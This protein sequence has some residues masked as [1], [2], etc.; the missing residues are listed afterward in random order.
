M[1][2]AGG[3]GTT[4]EID[5]QLDGET[6]A[7]SYSRNS[8]R[9]SSRSSTSR[10]CKLQNTGITDAGLEPL[11]G[12]SNISSI[13]LEGTAISDRGFGSLKTISSLKY[14]LLGG[15][16]RYRGGTLAWSGLGRPLRDY[17]P[18]PYGG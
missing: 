3:E 9:T 18:E 17:P 13:N 5:I 2:R 1:I 16:A 15:H 10:A 6:P 7:T 11:K 4:A 8:C 12:M 14:V